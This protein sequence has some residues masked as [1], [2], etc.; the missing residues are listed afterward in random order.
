MDD[1]LRDL[2]TRAAG[3]A[4]EE[5]AELSLRYA[6]LARDRVAEAS[7]RLKAYVDRKPVRALGIELIAWTPQI[8]G[9]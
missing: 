8:K 1:Q 6:A 5:L 4:A 3:P 7:E 2:E 9:N